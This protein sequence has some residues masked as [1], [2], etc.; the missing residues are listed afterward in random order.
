MLKIDGAFA[1]T[2]WQTQESNAMCGIV[3]K[4]SEHFFEVQLTQPLI[5][6]KVF[7]TRNRRLSAMNIN[8][9]IF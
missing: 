6:G 9:L 4:D 5:S 1:L 3:L 8:V 7:Q 2:L